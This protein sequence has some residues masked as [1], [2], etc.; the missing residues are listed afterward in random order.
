MVADI[1]KKIRKVVKKTCNGRRKMGLL[2]DEKIRKEFDE[3]VMK[4]VRVCVSYLWQHLNNWIIDMHGRRGVEA[5][6][7][8]GSGM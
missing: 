4:L 2:K 5:R 6:K 7:I 3:K 8:H 1:D